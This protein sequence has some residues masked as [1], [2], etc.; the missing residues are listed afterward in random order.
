[1]QVKKYSPSWKASNKMRTKGVTSLVTFEISWSAIV[2]E[3][4]FKAVYY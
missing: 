1:M 4:E 3:I 2:V